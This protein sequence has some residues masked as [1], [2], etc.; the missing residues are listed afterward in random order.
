MRKKK[1]PKKTKIAQKKEN[2]FNNRA[3]FLL[4]GVFIATE[5]IGLTVAHSLAK[6]IEIQP[7]FGETINDPINAAYLFGTI[8]VMTALILLLLKFRQKRNFL[9]I[10]ESL[11]VLS[12]SIIVFGVAIGDYAIIAALLLIMLRHLH[13]ENIWL[14]N[15]VGIIAIAGAGAYI[16]ISLGLLPILIFI[17]ALSC[18]DIIAVFGTKHMVSIGKEVSRGNFAFTIALPTKEHKFELGNGDLVIPLMVASGIMVNGPFRNNLAVSALCIASSFI[19]LAYSIETVSKKKIA[20]PAL[21]PQTALMLCAI[22][23]ASVFGM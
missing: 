3:F 18:Y 19:G 14:R 9:L 5:F 23:L 8:I 6:T 20:L 4:L 11:A 2:F 17:T 15:F 12:T 16:G 10:I 22:L 1:T 13:R 21:P 7:I